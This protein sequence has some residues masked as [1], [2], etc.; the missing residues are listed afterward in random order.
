MRRRRDSALIVMPA[1]TPSA[2]VMECQAFGATV[3]KLNGLS[4]I[5]GKYVASAKIAKAVRRFDAEGGPIASRQGDD[6]LRTL[7]EF[8]GNCR[9]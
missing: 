1:D 5:C 4:P 7:E 3:V 8:R 9:M 2:N 6:G